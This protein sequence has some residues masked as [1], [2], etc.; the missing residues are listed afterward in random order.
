MFKKKCSNCNKKIEKSYDFCPY[1]GKN[2]KS[3]YDDEDF[4]F[5]G[6]NDFMNEDSS[7]IRY[8]L[9]FEPKRIKLDPKG[10]PAIKK[11][12]KRPQQYVLQRH[13]K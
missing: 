2:F 13:G 1:C 8:K 3:K 4:G 12:G 9:N 11:G 10:Y 7:L 5:L 6:K